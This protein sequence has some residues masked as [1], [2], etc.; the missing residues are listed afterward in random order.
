MN[1]GGG[2]RFGNLSP[3]QQALFEDKPDLAYQQ[4]TDYFNGQG[5]WKE[6]TTFGRWLNSQQSPM[7]NRFVAQQAANPTG[8]LTWTRFLENQAPGMFG[9]FQQMPGYMRNS[10][11]GMMRVRR[12]LW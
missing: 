3:V 4:F 12:E 10:N 11:P 8:N 5:G 9:N 6:N 2:F 7:Y 1:W